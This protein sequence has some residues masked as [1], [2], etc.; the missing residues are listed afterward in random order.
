MTRDSAFAAF[1]TVVEESSAIAVS[2]VPGVPAIVDVSHR[3]QLLVYLLLL[4]SL[5]FAEAKVLAVA[6]VPSIALALV[7]LQY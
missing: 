6:G 2:N 1:P 3:H 5:L 4:A 7:W